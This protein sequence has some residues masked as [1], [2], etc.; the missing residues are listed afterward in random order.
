MVVILFFMFSCKSQIVEEGHNEV[1]NGIVGGPFEN[2]EFMYIGMPKIIP[3][4]DTSDAW[5]QNGQKLLI[6]GTIYK[7]DGKTPA[8]D[9][10]LYITTILTLMAFI[11]AEK[12]LIPEW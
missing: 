10:I 3:S 4:V 1:Q 9:V 7:L 6:T 11:L 2:G 8:P 12:D 5:S